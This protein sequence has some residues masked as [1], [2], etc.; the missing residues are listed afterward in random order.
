MKAEKDSMNVTVDGPAPV[1][2][3]EPEEIEKGLVHVMGSCD[4]ELG[5][6]CLHVVMLCYG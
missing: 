6:R 2:V 3:P 1:Q 4:L 5:K